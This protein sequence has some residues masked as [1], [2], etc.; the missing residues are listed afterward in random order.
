[1]TQATPPEGEADARLDTEFASATCENRPILTVDVERYAHFLDTVD[2]SDEDK[3]AFIEA[4]WLTIVGFIELGFGVHPTQKI[5]EHPSEDC[6]NYTP[7]AP[8]MVSYPPDNNTIGKEV[9]S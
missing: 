6:S 3:A 8:D 9:R 5:C 4:M 7:A 1:M 2:A